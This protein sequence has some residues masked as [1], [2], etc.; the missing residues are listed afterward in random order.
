MAHI[1]LMKIRVT[2]ESLPVGPEAKLFGR[3]AA[4]PKE[5]R[6]MSGNQLLIHAANT[7]GGIV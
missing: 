6:L 3:K 1:Y 4:G 2:H 7:I 5:R